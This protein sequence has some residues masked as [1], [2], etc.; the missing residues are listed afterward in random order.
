MSLLTNHLA[1]SL[2]KGARSSIAQ[3]FLL[4]TSVA[5]LSLFCSVVQGNAADRAA[6]KAIALG[7]NESDVNPIG[8]TLTERGGFDVRRILLAEGADLQSQIKPWVNEIKS[9]LNLAIV[10]FRGRLTIGDDQRCLLQADPSGSDGTGI[11]LADLLKSFSGAQAGS[12]VV[13]L[14]VEKS[15][16]QAGLGK[17]L[18]Q[19]VEGAP[20]GAGF[21]VIAGCQPAPDSQEE[22]SSLGCWANRALRGDADLDADG[23]VTVEELISYLS[24][25]L[26]GNAEVE[27]AANTAEVNSVCLVNK[28]PLKLDELLTDL[29]DKLA[30]ELHENGATLIAVPDFHLNAGLTAD[31]DVPG[32]DYGPLMRYSVT[33]LKRELSARSNFKYR[34]VDGTWLRSLLNRHQ[35]GPENIESERMKAVAD[36]FAQKL[37]GSGNVTLLV[38][39][40]QH[41]GGEE[42]TVQCTPWDAG[43]GATYQMVTG[44][45]KLNPSEWAMIGQSV[46]NREALAT[47][48]A[49]ATRSAVARPQQPRVTATS[50]SKPAAPKYVSKPLPLLNYFDEKDLEFISEEIAK[51]ERN[52][53]DAHP[54]TDAAFPY[55][56][57]LIVNGK[58]PVPTLSED[59]R[60]VYYEL[61]KND[62]Y[63]IKV[64]NAS[65]GNVFMRLLVDGLNTLPDLPLLKKDGADSL[66]EVAVKDPGAELTPAE[67]VNLTDARAWYCKPGVYS[68][69]GFFTMIDDRASSVVRDAERAAF[70][71]TDASDSEAWRKGYPKDVG[72]ITAAFYTPIEQ[73]GTMAIKPRYGTELGERSRTQVS[74]YDGR[75]VPG[76]L[77]AVVHLRYGIDPDSEE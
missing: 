36:E 60:H 72:I 9:E 45:A 54:L 73:S 8:D 74:V 12:V 38:G 2:P 7:V 62:R 14:D 39:G 10:Y 41:L 35:I 49:Q 17:S 50:A 34:L 22:G 68:I 56:V 1:P 4:T 37:P 55:K 69:Q 65:Q 28:R 23:R 77:L 57:W 32:Q 18:H 61:K 76:Q 43:S 70:V 27:S 66:Y 71:V 47:Q 46:V 63:T 64:Q 31:D 29:A 21:A 15:G 44:N 26:A 24:E 20:A 30:S 58:T 52:S 19:A 75:Q 53:L 59:G 40:F 6:K 33:K 48:V 25:S 5:L 11:A 67:Y 3:P 51:L 13:L 42:V 16:Q